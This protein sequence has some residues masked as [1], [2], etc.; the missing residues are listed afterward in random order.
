VELALKRHCG[1]L[2]KAYTPLGEIFTLTGKDLS[3]VRYLIGIGG[4]I[5]NSARPQYM[6]EGGCHTP[7]NHTY[8]L[9]RAPRY[10]Q[11]KKYIFS[12][13][14]LLSEADPELALNIM[15]QE[16]QQL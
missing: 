2:E 15:K 5:I 4:I 14:G 3:R 12:A 11:D 1:V 10:M 8:M 7:Q 16:M 13:A 6:L 9:P